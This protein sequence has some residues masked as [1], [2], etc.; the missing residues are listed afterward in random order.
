[1]GLKVNKNRSSGIFLLMSKWLILCTYLGALL[2]SGACCPGTLKH[3]RLSLQLQ[4]QFL[5]PEG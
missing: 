4:R 2:L 3:L 5:V 1:M